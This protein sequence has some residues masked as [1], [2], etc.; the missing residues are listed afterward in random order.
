VI[1]G[2]PLE[3]VSKF[4]HLYAAPVWDPYLTKDV[5]NLESVHEALHIKVGQQ[6]S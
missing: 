1:D 3:F 5:S 6:L 2:A 4:K